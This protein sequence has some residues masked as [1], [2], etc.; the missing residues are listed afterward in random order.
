MAE[1][2]YG[3]GYST[4]GQPLTTNDYVY[5]YQTWTGTTTLQP[6][7]QPV[8]TWVGQP[9]GVYVDPSVSDAATALAKSKANVKAKSKSMFETETPFDWLKRRVEE[10]RLTPAMMM[11]SM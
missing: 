2:N 10:I 7:F 1:Y 11:A 3:V 4:S 6:V 9:D 8:I 5:Q